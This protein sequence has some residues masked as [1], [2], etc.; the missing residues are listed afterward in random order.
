LRRE[1][2]VLIVC[3]ALEPPRN[4]FPLTRTETENGGAAEAVD[5]IYHTTQVVAIS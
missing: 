2:D 4:F 5:K 3:I 1:S